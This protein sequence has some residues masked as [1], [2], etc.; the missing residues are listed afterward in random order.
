MT[1]NPPPGPCCPA[2]LDVVQVTP[3]MSNVTWSPG[4]GARSYVTA[5]DSPRGHAKCHTMNTHCLMGCITC[6][7]NY[8]VTI[9]AISGTGHISNC[10]YSGFSS[11]ACCPTNVKLYRMSNDS[12]RVFWRS[13]GLPQTQ[14]YMVDVYGA[15]ANYTCTPAA[16]R[17]YCDVQDVLCGDV[18]TVVV[19]PVNPDGSK[20]GFCPRRMYSGCNITSI[21]SPSASTLNVAWGPYAGATVYLLT[22][23]A[24]DSSDTA[25]VTLKTSATQKVVQGLQPGSYYE[26]TLKPLY[27]NNELCSFTAYSYTVPA[28]PQL[29]ISEALSSSSIRFQWSNVTGAESYSLIVE[30][31]YLTKPSLQVYNGSFTSLTGQVDGLNASTRY[32]CYVYSYNSAGYG[33]KSGS[34]IVTTLVPPP[35]GVQLTPTGNSTATVTWYTRDKVLLYQVTISDNDDPS[36]PPIYRTTAKTS[37][38]I[39]NLE[40]CSNYTVGVSSVNNFFIAGEAANVSHTT[41]TIEPVSTVQASYSCMSGMV[42]VTWGLV[43]GANSY[44]ATAFDRNGTGLSCNSSST[45][46]QIANLSC[47]TEYEVRVT[48][49]SDDCESI[50]NVSKRFETVPCAP[51]GREIYRECGS[52]A[53]IF[54]WQPTNNT[55]YYVATST[56]TT[57]KRVECR[58]TETACFFTD[59]GCGQTYQYTVYAISTCNSEVSPPET[60]STSPCLPTTVKTTLNCQTE[61]LSATWDIVAGALDYLVEAHGNNGDQYNCSSSNNSCALASL[62]CGEH[63][64]VWITASNAECSTNQ[65]LGEP[66]ET[67]PCSPTNVSVIVDCSQDSAR[68]NWTAGRGAVFYIATAKHNNGSEHSCTSTGTNC[69][70]SGL[71]CGQNYTV[72]VTATNFKCNSSVSPDVVIP[73][74]PCPPQSI[75]AIIDCDANTAHIEWQNHRPTGIFTALLE[76]QSGHRLNCTSNTIN[77]CEISA[78]PCGRMYNVTVTYDDGSCPLTSTAIS[79]KSVPCVPTNV[80]ATQTCGQTSVPVS[81]LTSLGAAN[82]TAFAVSSTGQ[83]TECSAAGITCVLQD[84]LQCG[85]V[86]TI[87]VVAVGDNCT[88]QES[89]Y[90]SLSTVPCAPLN[91]SATLTCANH[92]ALV[93]WVGSPSATAYT[94]EALDQDGHTLQCH[95]NSTSCPLDHMRC[96][97]SYDIT[98]VPYTASCTGI[99]STT[100]TFS[101]GLCP[102]DNITVSP[103][104]TGSTVSWSL[105]PGAEMYI[106]MAT[107]NDGYTHNCSSD[108]THSSCSFTDLHCGGNYIVTVATIDRVCQSS[109]SSPVALRTALCPPTNLS[110]EVTCGP[111]TPMGIQVMWDK[112]LVSEATYTIYSEVVGVPGS[113]SMYNTTNTTFPITGLQCGQRHAISIRATDGNCTSVESPAI[114]VATAPCQPT[115]LTSRVDCGTNM[116]NFSWSQTHGADFYTVEVNGDDGHVDSCTSNDTSCVVRLHCGR[117]YSASLVAAA[118]GCN[119]S[120]HAAIHF[121]SAPC[122]PE[123][124]MA[125]LNCTTNSLM[126]SWQETP[127]SDNYTAL[128]I[129]SDG[130]RVSCNTTTNSCWVQDLQCGL[131]YGVVVK[132]SFTQSPC[133]PEHTNVDLNCS[134]NIIT[135]KWDHSSTAQNYT[136]R[137]THLSGM[138][139]T[140]SSSESS[141]SFLDLSWPPVLTLPLSF[142]FHPALCPPTNISA[143][144][145]CGT[146][147][148]LV[149]WSRAT[150][151]TAYSVEANSTNGH[152]SSCSSNGFSCSLNDLVC[153]EE[154]TVVVMAMDTGCAGP[155]SV[156]V[157][158]TTSPCIPQAVVTNVEWNSVSWTASNRNETYIAVATGLDSHTHRC[159]TTNSSCTWNDLHCGEE[160]TVQVMARN[161]YCTSLP[162][163]GSVIHMGPC[164]PQS[165]V[166]NVEC[167]SSIGYVSWTASNRNETYIAVATGLDNHTHQCVTTNSSCTWDDLHCG[168]EYTVQVM[169][170]NGNYTSLLING[171]VI[172]TGPCIPQAVVTNVECNS[173]ISSV[174]WT[175]NNKNETYIAVATGLNGHTHQCFTTDTSC[176]WDDLHCGEAYTVKVMAKNG[177]CTSLPSN[178]SVIH[179]GPCIPQ[180][181]VA[182][183]ESNSGVGSVSWTSSNR[184]ETYIAVATSLDSHT[185]RCVTT[186]SSCTWNDLHCGEE[187]NVQVMARNDY[188]TSLPSNSSVIHMGPCIPQSV[189]VN[190]EC[191]SSIGSVSWTSSNRNETYIVVATGLDNHTHQCVT[192]NSSCTLDDLHCGEEYTVNVMARNGNRTSLPSNSSV[193]H[194]GPCIPQAVVA[195]VESNSGVGSV[196][197]TS[198][199]RNETYIAVATGLDSHTHRCVTTNSSC[200]WNDLHCGEE[201]TVQVMARNDY[202]TSLPSNGSVIHMGPC[203]PQ[204][205]VANVECNSSIGSVSWTSSNRNETY[206]AVA[207]GLDNHTH[208]CVTTNSSCTLDDLHCGEE[209]TVNVM[210]RNGNRTS[211][212]SNSSVIHTGPCIP[213]AVVAKVESN[214][215]VGSVSW[216]SSNRNETYIAVATGLDSHTH[217]C[218]TTNSSCTWNDLHCGE[219][220]TVQVMARNDYCTSLPSNG[221]VI[222][223][224]PCIP[225]SV[226]VNVECNSSIGSVSWTSSNRNETYIVVATGLDNHTHQCVT[227]NSSCTL[228]DLHCGEEYTVN[229]MARNG[230]RTSLPSNSSVIHT[231]PCIPQAVV[232]KVES[233]SGVGSVSWTSSNR[234]ETYIAVA[235]GL[236]SHTHRC[237]TTNSS[238]T[239]NDLHCGEEYTVQ[240]MARNDYCNSL[241]SNGSIIHMGPCIPQSVVVNVEC[242]SSIGSVS[243][244]SSN[245][246]ETYIVVAT[247]LD[248]HTHQCVT[249]NSSCTLD[250]LHCGEEYTVN[251]MA[252]NGN[253]TSLPSNSSVIHTGPCIPQAVVAKVE[254]NSGVGS[255]SW[256]SSNR[257]ETYIAVATGLDSHTHRCVTT[258]SSCTWNDLHCGEEY[259]VQVMARNDYCNSL[260]SNGSIIHMGPCIPQSV[261][262]NVECN[263]SI[264]SVSWTSSNRNETYIV[265]ATGLDNH[266]HQCVTTNSSC[267]LDDL[268]C[269]EEYTVN[270][271]ARNGNRTSLPSN[272]SVI[273]TGPCI[274][275]A[276]VVKVESNSGVGSVSWTSSN[277]NETYIAVA[278]GLDSHT[279]RCVTTNSSCTWNDLHCGE[280]YTVQ[281]M[282]RND[283]C[284]SLPSNGSIIHMG[285]CIPQSV[286]VNV[287]CNSSI[288]SVSW[289]SSNRNETYIVVATGLD[290]HTHQCVTTNSS[291]TLDDLHCGEEYTVNVMARNGNRT[292]LPSNSSVIHTDRNAIVNIMFTC[293]FESLG[294]CIPQAVVAKVESNSGVGSVSW[295]SSNRNETYIAVA[296]GLDSHTHR[297]VTTNSSCTWNDLHCGE[298]YTVQ[299]M[300]RN[301]YC[302]SLPSN[303]SVIHMGPCIPQSVVANV[304]CNSSIGSVSW[305]SSNRNETYIAVATGLDNHTHQCVTTNSSC[306]WNDLHCGE[307]YTVN[308]MA[309]NGNRTSLP[310]NSSVIHTAPCQP[311][312]INGSLDCVTNSAWISWD[313]S[314]GAESYTVMSVGDGD[315]RLNCTT[316]TNTSCEVQ[317]LACGAQYNFSVIATNSHCDSMPSTAVELETAPCSLSAITASTQCHNSSILVV[318]ETMVGGDGNTQYTTTAEASDHTYLSCNTTD[319]QCTLWGARCGLRYTIL[320]AASSDQCSG[321]RSPPYRISMEPCPPGDLAVNTSCVDNGALVSW[322]PSPVATDYHVSARTA[323]GHVHMCNTSFSNCSLSDLHCGQQYTVSVTASHENCSSK[324]SQ[325][326]N[327]NTGPCIPQAVV[328]NVEC[329][330]SIGSVSWTAINRNE[331]Y[332]A[333]ATGL[334]AHTHRCVTTNSSCTWD[335]LHC[336]EEYTVQVMARNSDCTSLPSNSTVIHTGPCIPQAV[337]TIVESNSGVGS[338]SWTSR[339]RNETYIAVA[340]GLD[341]HTHRC[342]TTNSSCTWN[343]LHCG[344][345]YTVHVMARND[346][347]T[348]LPSNSSVIH[349]GP[350]IPQSV[351][352]NVEC[353]SSIGSVSW[354]SSNR[355][356]TY[357]AVAMGLD[358]HTHQCVT[359]NSSC[360]LD[361]LHCGEEYTVNVMARN[362]NRTSLPSNSSVIHTGPCIP[363]AVV[364]KVESNSGVGSVSWTS[365]NRNETYIAVATGLDSHTH[366]CVTTNSSCTWNDLHCGEEYTVQVMARND[367]CTS[368]PSNGSV[369]HMGPCIPQSVVVNV[370]CT[371]SIGSVSW[372]SSNRNETYIAVAMGLDNHTHQCVTTNS[373]CT[374]DDLHC[375]EEYT[376]NVMARNG[377]RTSLPSN[378]SVIHTG[379]CIPQAVVAK[380]ESN[381][382][383]GSVS[384]TSSNRNETYIAVATGL[385][386]HTHRCVTTNSSCTWND[387]HCGEEYTVQVMARNDYC[388]SLPSNGSVIHMGPCIPQSVVV[389]VECTASIGSV[390]WTSSNRNETYI[391]VAMGLDN[392]TH[393][394]VTTNSSCTL[395]DLHCGEEYTVNVMARNGN[396]TSLPSNSSV[397]HTG[398][399]I[400]QAVVAKVESNSGVGSVSWT[401][402]NRNETYI[403]VATGLDSHTHRC[404]TTN[405]SCTWNDLH[406]GEEYTVQVMAR[407]DYC[408]SLPSNGSVIH[409]GPCIPH[410]VVA[411]VECNSSIGSVSWTSSNRN[412]TYIAVATGLDNHT[413]QCVTTNSSCTLDDLHCGEEY[414]VNVMARNGN[415]T[416]LPSNSSVIHTGPCIPQ[417]VVA[418]VESN[419]GVGS[420]SWTSSNR[421][422]TYIAVA[423]SL[424]S[425]THR[426]VTTNSSCTWNDL[427]CGEEYTVQVMA[428]NDYCTSL[429][430]NSSVIHTAPCQPQGINGS[431]DCV[432]NSAWISWDSSQGAES[433]TV[434]SV[435]DGDHRLNCT[436]STNTSCEVQDLACGAQYNFSVIAT[437]SHFDSMPSTAVELE[438]VICQPDNLSA[439]VHCGNQSAVLSWTPRSGAVG[440]SASAETEGGDT[441]FCSSS[442][443]PT[444]T[445][446]GLQCGAQYNFSV[447]ASDGTCN[448]SFSEPVLAA[449][450][451]PD[452]PQVQLLPMESS[453][454]QLHF[455]WSQVA[456]PDVQYLL[457]LTG[458]LLGDSQAQF[459]LSS[460]WTNS[461]FFEMPLP[462]G[463]S[464]LAAVQSRGPAGT[465]APS[466]ALNG[467]TA[468]C[469]PTNVTFTGNTAS[470]VLAWDASVFA[471]SYTVYDGPDVCNATELTCS[472]TDVPH[473]N[474]LITASNAAGESDSAV[475]H[476]VAAARR[477]RD[478]RDDNNAA[479]LSA[480]IVTVSVKTESVLVV[481]WS[482]VEGGDFY[483]LVI[484]DQQNNTQTLRVDREST[485]LKDLIP[486]STYCLSVRA[487]SASIV[488]PYSETQCVQT[489]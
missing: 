140:C 114:E 393:Q 279:H 74:A 97:Q 118:R 69:L 277:R 76:D 308:V 281:V 259:T 443:E 190:V 313:S 231:G 392:H 136:V 337:V 467:N 146:G 43:F 127:G 225:Q 64:S 341:S 209:Y 452:V 273:H 285:P 122:L 268:H 42:T 98:V 402:S 411:N 258:N 129:G 108:G 356:E 370:E 274:P 18:Y 75:Q 99:P 458:S 430:S 325:N 299:V 383:V 419:S 366:R 73:T 412:E 30:L 472:L 117:S 414:T 326:V 415:R 223:M 137:A 408:T 87:G 349:M 36:V 113:I 334:D 88:S 407:N 300:A 479:N 165:V 473:G 455:K 275:Q 83:R 399:C 51:V 206:I 86:Y 413:H 345:E 252:R 116:G 91:V 434:M 289:T 54:S 312:G 484:A 353:N 35:T 422:E 159:V 257:N 212:P 400:P 339:N 185:H 469:S 152:S 361:D 95:S 171:S 429:P 329:N 457:R 34:K 12:M 441:L 188:C 128:A 344:E 150:G 276:V 45:S 23:K 215:G 46:C 291:C 9:E 49:I 233:N 489:T 336:D 287:E 261:V 15:D 93:S 265:V 271:M 350:C 178:S 282:A 168:E 175:S 462:C 425:H 236:D 481:K 187:Y 205:V 371:S 106:A 161:D 428:R 19:A 228:D 372:T 162:S 180:A 304:E 144:L 112:S 248:N 115:N 100:Y 357:I 241:P 395:D 431:L 207:T 208:Q 269:G 218:V 284:T 90:G 307:E 154:Y 134:S 133:K 153:G 101:A 453:V 71:N 216:T 158:L 333:V 156:P 364:A 367:Y 22:L 447:R 169:A 147:E 3:A 398:P 254:S 381:S 189:V 466:E 444:C 238:C 40:P 121:H 369:I 107:G 11:S 363:Q 264:G 368:L 194:T 61:L 142:L 135:V 298:E 56:D 155:T 251:V 335:D 380:V 82:Y 454:Q 41:A 478:L 181:V 468:P 77:S 57:G 378:S 242:N 294:P 92:S 420:V 240:V 328:A 130:H 340:T 320:V 359:T 24:L 139:S 418:K 288:G 437:N 17:S 365:S 72:T 27:F 21:S 483:S 229:V 384:W 322:R 84:F 451:P 1:L 119:S 296:T 26:V 382:G 445:I 70:I 470:A 314:P 33:A 227:T 183:V 449:P 237:V 448:S 410:S 105:R 213:Q 221:S 272:S 219:E 318:W 263:S 389:N 303:G 406:C 475:V 338:V 403:A 317:D 358:N 360:T 280:E 387:L 124:V 290:N 485:V 211:L 423:T 157:N 260:P 172:R 176:I 471:T 38:D 59:N 311:Q 377:N 331:T 60:I 102:P 348:S 125:V 170:R 432:T 302:T 193:I 351:V 226:V 310:S 460:Y 309:R 164:I 323:E 148:A 58:T 201:Y 25:T 222:H 283:Y 386:S 7:T 232:A 319:T 65:V 197:W 477:R 141:C 396:R 436:T 10:T 315:H 151:A 196:S 388:T 47:G 394:C 149:T 53:I 182:K 474:V 81:W 253:R 123:N 167:N 4:H 163:N 104:C 379:P 138:N 239:W 486:D 463:S 426:C 14:N 62:P 39:A 247:G 306:T 145:D 332:I 266:T 243:W 199:N 186:N 89:Q 424:D 347:C 109:P 450:C 55:Q 427:H 465:S 355:N 446:D 405:S 220:Y 459:D 401:S 32:S 2:I 292:S 297:C 214:S 487:E 198:S 79:M 67:V 5:L 48:A 375:G 321:L 195:K 20:V 96:G 461:T 346:Y 110:G 52:N 439:T 376:V 417:A 390:S 250:D 373:S 246:N 204:S 416:S 37:M 244:T 385:D 131:T 255:V 488:G 256:T 397:I 177:N 482:P 6:G 480:P 85:Q 295:T 126:V 476:T 267:T 174:S 270:V 354:T 13:S 234:N 44:M 63:L 327:F 132:S 50:S 166:A 293:F 230:N 200:T 464:Y 224:G 330:S 343:D 78:L 278:T 316:A 29:T 143:S 217:R 103:Q 111:H 235:T 203:I 8:N 28:T 391:A 438:T 245:R 342:V 120:E 16:S 179:T 362:G 352:V 173:S 421:N 94:V 262:V 210:A 68:V 286:V 202:C 184:N 301:D 409:M 160:Y 305:T 191:N 249:T 66:A 31:F 324:A 456:C 435:G 374:L 442:S 80:T 404:V 440:Y 192:T 433:Y